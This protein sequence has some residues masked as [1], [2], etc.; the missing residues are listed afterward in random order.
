MNAEAFPTPDLD[1]EPLKPFWAAAARGKLE[2]PRC[3]QCNTFNWY[4]AEHCPQCDC[5][6]FDWIEL[7]PIGTVFSWSE[8][9]RPLYAPYAA[10]A[11]YVPIIVELRDAPNVRLVTRLVDTDLT[12][13]RIGAPV[14]LMFADLAHPA[15]NT[16]VIAPLARIV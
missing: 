11:P 7:A 5:A 14:E 1:F 15:A 10:I 6:Q 8:V 3:A 12:Q 9:K 2:L 13:L 16:G 4:P